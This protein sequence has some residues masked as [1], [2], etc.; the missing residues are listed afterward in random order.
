MPRGQAKSARH[1]MWWGKPRLHAI[2]CPKICP[3]MLRCGKE[4]HTCPLVV[5]SVAIDMGRGV[6]AC[7]VVK[8]SLP[9]ILCGGANPDCMPSIALKSAR[10]CCGAARNPTHALWWCKVWLSTWRPVGKVR[11]HALWWGKVPLHAL[12]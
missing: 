9:A 3:P 7:H 10:Q 1:S 12:G 2:H 5:Q 11:P 4:P 6:L 8:Q